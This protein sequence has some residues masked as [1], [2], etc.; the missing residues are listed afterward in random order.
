M[1]ECATRNTA[2]KDRW[3]HSPDGQS[4]ALGVLM[5]Y[6][7][8]VDLD[9]RHNC[10]LE[11]AT[12]HETA[13]DVTALVLSQVN[14]QLLVQGESLPTGLTRELLAYPELI[15][16][17]HHSAMVFKLFGRLERLLATAAANRRLVLILVSLVGRFG[18]GYVLAVLVHLVRGHLPERPF[19]WPT[20]VVGPE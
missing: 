13:V 5:G 10:G 14:L 9:V 7:R 11:H 16:W 1:L 12:Q 4:F 8:N 18:S 2:V 6:A 20:V 3:V 19:T 17:V 15:R